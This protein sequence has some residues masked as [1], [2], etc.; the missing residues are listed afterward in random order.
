MS[1]PRQ[2]LQIVEIDIEFC[3]LTF[4]V[5]LCPAASDPG[6][7]CY[8][9]Y[10]T[11][12]TAATKAAFAANNSTLTLRFSKNQQTGFKDQ[13]IFPA[14]QGVSTN[15]TRI[16]LGTAQRESS[17]RLGSLGKRARVSVSLKDF[18]WT[19]QIVDPY[20][21]GRSYNPIEQ[22]TFFGKLR[23]RY[24]YYYGRALRVRNGYVGDTIA[25]MPTRH[26]I[27]TEWVGPDSNGNVSITA[28]DPLKLA[29]AE[30]AL[31]PAPSE[32]RLELDLDASTTGTINFSA[33]GAG[34]DY[35]ASGKI[36]IGGEIMAYSAKTSDTITISARGQDGTTAASHSAGD[37]IQQC[38]V[39]T[40]AP[41]DDVIKDLLQNFAGI[42]AAFLPEADWYSEINTWLPSMRFT[43]VIAEPTPVV[44]LLSQIADFG[45]VFWWSETAQEI[46]LKVNRPVGL[47]E[48]FANLTDASNII[49]KSAVIENLDDQRI[50]RAI[51]W[52]GYR[53]ATASMT[54]G[55][56]YNRPLPVAID[57]SAE[58]AS[59][60][61]QKR[62]TRIYLPW[63]GPNGNDVI[64]TTVGIRLVNRYRDTPQRLT[65]YADI[66]D[67]D[68]AGIADLV[69]VTN[70]TLQDATGASLATEMQ[71]TSVEEIK[72]GARLKVVAET[73]QFSGRY[74]F[75]ADEADVGVDYTDYSDA[76]EA[77]RAQYVFLADE[78]NLTSDPFGTGVDEPYLL[79]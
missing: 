74:A 76:T 73:Y 49:E 19:D 27:I 56:N 30:F 71:V 77:E 32:G 44:D 46:R 68:D 14:L 78:N 72:P 2:P 63:L 20:V 5:G 17:D 35:A 12:P 45:I 15:P 65:F 9:T 36:A 26:Y 57:A 10:K 40:S 37:T 4:S 67:R 31:C 48:T 38:Y 79:F 43:R 29:D 54:S 39:K 59:E 6:N 53:D 1:D 21:S 34:D 18:A 24:P 64:A 69:R 22:G 8:N 3:D 51:V 11:C 23:A 66:K 58:S 47:T 25:T 41:P 62:I 28:Q 61:N 16:A 75:L 42:D 33:A 55:D 50:S 7:E 13:I 52:H 60:Y 70:R